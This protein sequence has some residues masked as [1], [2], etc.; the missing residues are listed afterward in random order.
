MVKWDK[1]DR[2]ERDPLRDGP[3]A[4]AKFLSLSGSNRCGTGPYNDGDGR[5]ADRSTSAAGYDGETTG[6]GGP[7]AP[8]G[9]GG[10]GRTVLVGRPP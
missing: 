6:P 2:D 10:Y 1:N 3:C 5:S 4:I 9:D 7:L 8:T